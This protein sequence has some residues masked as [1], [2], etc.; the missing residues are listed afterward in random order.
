MEYSEKIDE[1]MEFY[2]KGAEIGRLERGLGIVEAAR[3]KEVLARYLE[4]GMAVYDVG[5]GIGY[6]TGWLA[7]MGCTATLFELAPH[8]VAYAKAHQ[9]APYAA[10]AADARAL[11][12]GDASCD[13]LLLMGP[14]Y[15]LLE[16]ESRLQA[17]AEARRVLRPEGRLIAAG[18]SRFSSATWALSTYRAGND[19]IDDETYMGMLR[20]ELTTGVHRRPEKY[21]NFIA[22]AYFHTPE[23]LAGELG[24]A[25]F[26]TEA[27]VAVEGCI[28]FTPDLARKW[29]DPA[30]RARLLELVRLTESEPSLLGFSPHFLAIARKE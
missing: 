15:H 28:W 13:A 16:K 7:E 23:A 9:P 25:G 30:A 6:Y 12:A 18:I 5:G 22:Q 29:A 10:F 14:L 1:V 24:E 8:A 21:P 26:E 4:P 20:E 3:T 27:L 17:L 2:E 11:P 19:F